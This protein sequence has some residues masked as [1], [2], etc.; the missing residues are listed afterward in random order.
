MEQEKLDKE[1]KINRDSKDNEVM[2]IR[3]EFDKHFL[4][5]LTKTLKTEK[6]KNHE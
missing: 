4:N 1:N 2:E 6:A 3:K 5:E